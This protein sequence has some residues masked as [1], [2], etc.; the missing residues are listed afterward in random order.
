MADARSPTFAERL[1]AT[2]DAIRGK[3]QPEAAKP[4]VDKVAGVPVAAPQASQAISPQALLAA[5]PDAVQGLRSVSGGKQV[6]VEPAGAQFP[7]QSTPWPAA[8][9]PASHPTKAEDLAQGKGLSQA[10]APEPAKE[11]EHEKA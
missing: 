3:E 4:A 10:R 9:P 7:R 2:F 8:N 6:D 11:R 5:N 1:Y